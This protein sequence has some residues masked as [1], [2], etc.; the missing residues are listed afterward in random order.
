METNPASIVRFCRRWKLTPSQ[1]GPMPIR[2]YMGNLVQRY[3]LTIR[4]PFERGD[5]CS[6]IIWCY[7]SPRKLAKTLDMCQGPEDAS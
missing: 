4:K 6:L 7:V 5:L 2:G 1:S 3:R